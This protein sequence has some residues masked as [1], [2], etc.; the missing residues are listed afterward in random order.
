MKIGNYIYELLYHH[1]CVIVADFGGFVAQY[2]SASIHPVQH[3]FSPP[4]KHIAF[5]RQLTFNDGLLANYISTKLLLSYPDACRIIN[6][7]VIACNTQ[8]ENGQKIIIDNVGELCLDPEKNIQ[9]TPFGEKNFLLDSFGLSVIQSPAIQ[10][11]KTFDIFNPLQDV[12]VMPM[13]KKKNMLT[14]IL[15]IAAITG[16]AAMLT[17]AY[18][19]PVI[20]GK[21]N[22]G[23]AGLFPVTEQSAVSEN[24]L[25]SN[26][27]QTL[28]E[29]VA[30]VDPSDEEN[31]FEK[32]VGNSSNIN[33]TSYGNTTGVTSTIADPTMNSTAVKEE[34]PA[35]ENPI[36]VKK[37][38]HF[39]IIGGCFSISENALKLNNELQTKGFTS[40][41]IGKNKNG[42]DMVAV[43]S[44]GTRQEAEA[45]L[46]TVHQAGYADAWIL[47]K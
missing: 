21:I 1:D 2:K 30:Q 8:L 33:E 22:K 44:F 39:Y 46:M 27:P 41:I 36:P 34:I 29:K 13:A 17:W 38:N 26:L 19:N 4:S 15:R 5:N 18:F 24:K 11:E 37:D 9:F 28:K 6:D 23:I 7:F 47:K 10:R 42:L 16:V 35:V 20:S 31:I 32:E 3:T 45:Q 12:P 43:S 40:S 25:T 14:P